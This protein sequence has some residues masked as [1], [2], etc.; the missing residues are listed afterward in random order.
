MAKLKN[1]YFFLVVLY[2]GMALAFFRS[3]EGL[4]ALW[5]LG[6]FIFWRETIKPS[7]LLFVALA[8]W[9]SYFAINTFIIRSFHPMFMGIYIAKIMIAYWLISHYREHLFLKYENIIY[10]LTIISLAFYGIQLIV[11]DA[12]MFKL[13]QSID[14]SEN[15]FPRKFY[16]SI[17]LYTFHQRQ[18]SELFPR[19]SGFCWEPGPFSSYVLLALFINIAR[20]GVSLNDKKRL[21]IFLLAIVTAQSTTSFIVLLAVI[22]WYAWSSVKNKAFRILSVPVAA[23]LVLYLFISLPWLQKKI[24]TE[25]EQDIEEV[26]THASRTGGSY[27]PGR[28]AS[29]QLRWEDFK[30]YPIAGYGGNTSLQAGYLGEENVVSAINGVGTILGKYGSIGFLIFLWLIFKTGKWLGRYYRYTSHII[31]TLLILMIGFG[32]GIIES[33]LV[34]SLY[35]VPVFLP[36]IIL[37]PHKNENPL[38]H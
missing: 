5:A 4:I 12:S 34:V 13:F 30:N 9:L 6:L 15:L 31:F 37:T 1:T 26:L 29:F 11:L 14:L 10:S 16:A 35:M 22:V 19:N 33:P 28:F 38:F 25:S 2:S 21:L 8:V 27:A 3:H 7:K 20:N 17:G 24:I 32:F 36:H 18:L 23:T